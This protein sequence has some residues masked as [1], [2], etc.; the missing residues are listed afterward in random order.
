M[1]FESDC[2]NC[3]DL[4][5]QKLFDLHKNRTDRLIRVNQD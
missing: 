4:T 3:I 1:Q 5:R 2:R